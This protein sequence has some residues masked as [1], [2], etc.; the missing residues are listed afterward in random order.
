MPEQQQPVLDVLSAM[1]TAGEIRKSALAAMGG[2]ICRCQ[3]CSF[4]PSPGLH[5]AEQ[6]ERRASCEAAQEAAEAEK[7]GPAPTA[8]EIADA[9]ARL[10]SFIKPRLV[11]G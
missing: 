10:K 6:R 1:I 2:L 8:D 4:D 5:L 7:R 3:Q 11:H 9:K